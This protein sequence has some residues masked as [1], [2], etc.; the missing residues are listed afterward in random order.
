MLKKCLSVLL[1][2]SA[3][4]VSADVKPYVVGDLGF[5]DTPQDSSFVLNL[6][7]GIHFNDYVDLEIAY[8]D[9]GG[10]DDVSYSSY[11]LGMNVGGPVSDSAR[12]FLTFGA[13]RLKT[14]GTFRFRG[15]SSDFESTSTEGFVGLGA[16]FEM[17][18][19][20]EIRTRIISRGRGDL[21]T[22]TFGF[23]KFF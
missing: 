6:G 23:V 3:P 16:A 17:T 14:D 4:I 13:E 8:N 9:Y 10:G 20:S 7:T 5:A 12:M 1:C 11:S 21:R 2:V 19:S 22:L 18:E 15:F